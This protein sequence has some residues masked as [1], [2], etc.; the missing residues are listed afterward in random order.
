MH[1]TPNAVQTGSP[2]EMSSRRVF[3]IGATGTIGQATVRALLQRGH[4]VVCFVRPRAGVRGALAADASRQLL[5][6]AT[7]RFGAVTDPAALARDGLCGEH[8]D[9]LVSCLASRTGAPKD[10]WAVDHQ[11]HVHALEAARAAGVTQ[12]VLLSAMCVQKPLLAFQ[13]AKLAFEKALIESGLTYSIVR[14]TAFFKS[15][16]GQIER[17]RRGKPFLLFGDGRLTACKPI[18]DRDLGD[19]LAD[20]LDQPDRHNRILPIGGPGPAITSREQGDKLFALLGRQPKFSHVPVALLDVIIAVLGTL[21]RLS[22]TLADKAELARIG[23]YYATESM[24]VLNP[25]TGQYDAD[26]TPS[27]GTET[28]FDFYADL[29]SGK[30]AAE[31]GDHA[32]F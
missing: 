23:R 17:V 13:H 7:V 30:V 10:A 27:T 22:P 24:L 14:P 26:A 8:F 12:V 20:C 21:G 9:V 25:Q 16:S 32:V 1:I 15:L 28:L 18:S 3:V 6:G 29:A 2:Q 31:R 5:Q 19:Y 4:Q 11:T